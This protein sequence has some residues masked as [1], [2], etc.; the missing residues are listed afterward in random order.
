LLHARFPALRDSLPHLAL[1]RAAATPVRELEIGTPAGVELWVK[2]DG[3]FGSLMGGNKVRKLEWT[4][5]DA[6]RRRRRS[7]VTVGGLATNHGLATSLYARDAGLRAILALADQPLDDHVRRQFEQIL[8]SGAAVHLTGGTV[9]TALTV[10]WL[11]LRNF[12]LRRMRAPYY[13]GVGGSSPL[14][15]VAFVE[16]ALELAAQVEAGV[17]PEPAHVVVAAGSGGTAAGLVLGLRMAG[18]RTGVVAVQVNDRTPLDARR[19]ARLARR[20]ESLLRARG[21]SFAAVEAAERDVGFEGGFLGGGYGHRTAEGEAAAQAARDRAGL[22]LEPVYTAKAMAAVIALSRNGAF[23]AGPVLYW[24]TRDSV[25][26][27]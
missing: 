25:A 6:L 4:L 17:L 18:L 12:D 27:G 10:P 7:I 19:I 3:A 21:A 20:T 9:R 11:L 13:L 1:A 14:G 2:D 15:C 24:H 8:A 22:A 23:G 26:A 5:A 16:A